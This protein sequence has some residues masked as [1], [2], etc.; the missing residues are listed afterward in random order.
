MF[1]ETDDDDDV[2]DEVCGHF[3]FH[4]SLLASFP[5][6]CIYLFVHSLFHCE[7]MCVF[8]FSSEML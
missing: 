4:V 1:E 8:V 2:D 6:H 5:L 7:C 3:Q